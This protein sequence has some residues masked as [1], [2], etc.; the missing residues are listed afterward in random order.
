[1]TKEQ[2]YNKFVRNYDI[3]VPEERVQEMYDYFLLQA[4]HNMQ[5]DTLSTG[6]VHLNKAAELA[7]LE[8]ELRENAY[9]EAKSDLVMKEM[10]KKLDPQV[11]QEELEA[12]AQEIMKR[13][14]STLDMIHMFFGKDLAGLKRSVQE[15]KVK[16]YILEQ[17]SGN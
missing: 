7:E 17:V 8:P 4:K 16:T 2:A 10:L 14:N 5:Y 3:E 15:D 11:S 1:M 12:K 13:E 6:R 9:L